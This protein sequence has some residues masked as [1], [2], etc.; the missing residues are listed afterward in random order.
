MAR[1]NN[2]QGSV[3]L[4]VTFLANGQIGG[5]SPIRNLPCGL[6]ERAIEAANQI[7][8]TPAMRNGK[9]YSIS[10]SLQFNFAIN[11]SYYD[12]FEDLLN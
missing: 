2:V 10:K 9:P 1:L 12:K 4:K 5:V 3:T 7:E 6:T 8:F 11:G